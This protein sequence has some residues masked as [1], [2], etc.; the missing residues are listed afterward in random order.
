MAK[1]FNL[2]DSVLPIQA[3]TADQIANMNLYGVVEGCGITWN[4]NLSAT[5]AAGKLLIDGEVEDFA[6]GTYTIT[7]LR[8]TGNRQRWVLLTAGANDSRSQPAG[9]VAVNN[10]PTTYPLMPDVAAEHVLLGA[11]LLASTDSSLSSVASSN[12]AFDLRTA[13]PP[14]VQRA[15]EDVAILAA[16][17][18][19]S[20][21]YSDLLTLDLKPNDATDKVQLRIGLRLTVPSGGSIQY[22]IERRTTG[23][24]LLST[25]LNEANVPETEASPSGFDVEFPFFDEP[26]TT[27]TRRYAVRVKRTGSSV[28]SEVLKG[29]YLYA[30]EID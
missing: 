2:A 6:G 7:S 15:N 20:S 18:T 1:L 26:A 25:V 4:N 23:G 5:V 27:S 12:R 3:V 28:G 16:D 30:R 10:P 11:V 13:A 21:G 19:P 22:K 17:E 8:P 14:R 9:V 24:N 29:S